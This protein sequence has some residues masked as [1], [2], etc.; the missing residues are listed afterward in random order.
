MLRATKNLCKELNINLNEQLFLVGYSQGGHVT[1]AVHKEIE[2]KYNNEF[3]ITASAP[4]ASPIDLSGLQM[5][6]LLKPTPYVSP[7]YLPYVLY[8]LNS[9]Y[10]IYPDLNN[11]FI[12]PYNTTLPNYFTTSMPYSL[13]QL[14]SNLPKSKIP[15]EILKA[16]EL[17]KIKNNRQSHPAVLAL[18]DNDLYD[19]KPVAPMKLCH[20][21]GD[22]H[23]FYQNSVKAKQSFEKNGSATIEII[24]PLKG[25]THE[26]C[27]IPSVIWAKQ[28]FDSMKK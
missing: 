1:L 27:L 20:C 17:E 28:W 11:I 10:K 4:M 26:T 24:N 25:G 9:I 22:R 6:S 19:W 8:G 7:G 3:K 13:Q 21:D 14:E 23:V 2:A 18:K 16:E 12:A 15:T 5:D